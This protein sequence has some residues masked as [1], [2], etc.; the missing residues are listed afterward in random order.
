[1]LRPV[2]LPGVEV[3]RRRGGDELVWTYPGFTARL[4]QVGPPD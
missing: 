2:G 1:V 4:A 3:T